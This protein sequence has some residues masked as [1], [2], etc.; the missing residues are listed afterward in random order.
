VSVTLQKVAL[1][2]DADSEEEAIREAVRMIGEPA[3]KGGRMFVSSGRDVKKVANPKEHV[4]VDFA[5]LDS[6]GSE[7][8]K[9]VRIEFTRHR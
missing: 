6:V 4:G 1:N 2:L 5:P 8:F 9:N 7:P 3:A